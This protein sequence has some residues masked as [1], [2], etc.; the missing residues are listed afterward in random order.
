M[1]YIENTVRQ[2]GRYNKYAVGAELR[3]YARRIVRTV[4]KANNLE[5][6]LGKLLELR[7]LLEETKITLQLCKSIRAFHNF[8]SFQVA[9][10]MVIDVSKQNEGWIRS[11]SG[12]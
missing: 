6:K 4:V 1:V 9:I 7:E 11:V 5:D 3:E 8:N 2:F 12:K 10:N